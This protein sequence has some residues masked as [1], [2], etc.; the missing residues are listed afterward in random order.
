MK[1]D[2]YN[3]KLLLSIITFAILIFT[4]F[5]VGFYK[6][7]TEVNSKNVK[8]NNMTQNV[9]RGLKYAFICICILL[10]IFFAGIFMF[11]ADAMTVFLF[12]G[13][14]LEILLQVVVA[15]LNAL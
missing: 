13:K 3:Y 1:N 7:Y 4:A 14:F 8:I 12:G 2:I 5:V 6:S 11:N 10:I 15:L 9:L